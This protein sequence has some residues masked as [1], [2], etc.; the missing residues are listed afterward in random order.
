MNQNFSR[1]QDS[2]LVL[3]TL[4]AL[5]SEYKKC[6]LK[7]KSDSV[8]YSALTSQIVLNACSYL[9]EWELLGALSSE[10]PR[11]LELRKIAKPAIDRIKKWKDLKLVRNSVIAHNHRLPKQDNSLT[12]TSIKRR[13]SCPNSLFDYKLLIGCVYVTK[14]A[15]LRVFGEEYNEIVPYLKNIEQITPVNEIINEKRYRK[16]RD[17]VVLNVQTELNEYYAKIDLSDSI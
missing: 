17:E 1:L 3:C 16:E 13:L 4:E 15:L 5:L 12:I 11:I 8:V 10:E 14:N 9:E 6:L 2:I 7:E